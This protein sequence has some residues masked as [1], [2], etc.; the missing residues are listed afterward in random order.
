MKIKSL[1]KKGTQIVI[2]NKVNNNTS[3]SV[4]LEANKQDSFEKSKQKVTVGDPTNQEPLQEYNS[5]TQKEQLKNALVKTYEEQS[6]NE[7]NDRL[8]NEEEKSLQFAA[9][10]QAIEKKLSEIKKYFHLTDS[11]NNML[12]QDSDLEKTKEIIK[13]DIDEGPVKK[14]DR[15][16]K[17]HYVKQNQDSFMKPNNHVSVG[18][19]A[20]PAQLEISHKHKKGLLTIED[21]LPGDEFNQLH[22]YFKENDIITIM[23][24]VDFELETLYFIPGIPE[25][26]VSQ[27]IENIRPY[28]N[29]S[30]GKLKELNTQ[31]IPEKDMIE[32]EI[33]FENNNSKFSDVSISSDIIEQANIEVVAN[34]SHEKQTLDIPIAEFYQE[35]PR[36]QSF[37]QYCHQNGKT[38]MSEITRDD[39]YKIKGMERY[40]IKAIES[41]FTTWTTFLHIRSDKSA[42]DRYFMQKNFGGLSRGNLFIQGCYKEGIFSV[43]DLLQYDLFSLELPSIGQK[44]IKEIHKAFLSSLHNP[45][46]IS[47][48]PPITIGPIPEENQF[49]PLKSLYALGINSENIEKF[50]TK[51]II[52]ASD[53]Y[54]NEISH[55]EYA[56]AKK[57]LDI[58]QVPLP[59]LITSHFT[60]LDERNRILIEARI[61]GKTLQQIGESNNITRERVRQ[62]TNKTIRRSQPLINIFNQVMI[63]KYNGVYSF[64]DIE[65][66]F[67]NESIAKMTIFALTELNLSYY[68]NFSHIFLDK[69]LVPVDIEQILNHIAI[70]IIGKGVDYSKQTDA[71]ESELS[72]HALEF[73]SPND[74]MNYLISSGY[75][76]Y[77]D[78]VTKRKGSYALICLD[79]IKKHFNFDI[80]LDQDENNEDMQNLREIVKIEYPG[81][82]LPEDNHALYS[83]VSSYLVLS[84]RGRYCPIEKVV[85]CSE[86]FE[87]IFEYI[88]TSALTSF[89]YTELFSEYQGQ[90]LA[91]T[92]ID[93]SH[94]LHGVLKYLY[95]NAY[96]YERD[97]L[98]KRGEER[99]DINFR[100]NDM[101]ANLS[102]PITKKEIEKNL[103]G[104]NSWVITMTIDRLP[105]VI[106]WDYNEFMHISNIDIKEDEINCI[107]QIILSEMEE[108]AG[109]AS[110][111]MIFNSI[112]KELPQVIMRNKIKS[113]QNIFYISSW[114]LEG[115][116]RFSRPHIVSLDFPVDDLSIINITKIL[117]GEPEKLNYQDLIGFTENLAWNKGTVNALLSKIFNDYIRISENEYVKPS[118][119]TIS[120]SERCEV[121]NHLSDIFPASG[122]FSIAN[123]YDFSYFP[124]L[125]IL[126]ANELE[127]NGFLLES[128]IEEVYLGYAIVSPKAKD[129]RVQKGL[130]VKYGSSVSS[131][132]DLIVNTLSADNKQRLTEEEFI[133]FLKSKGLSNSSYLPQELY[134]CQNLIYSNGIFQLETLM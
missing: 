111:M 55:W 49:I 29:Y 83:R 130:I 58:L 45:T 85:Y 110:E 52:Y 31:L 34:T 50:H 113:S 23:D 15:E 16:P 90:F 88:E 9:N 51:G 118:I 89:Y 8:S 104:I 17:G 19:P 119:F 121:S 39:F 109:Y 12:K 93:N 71:I 47:H 91:E 101:L 124:E 24:L 73:L 134:D 37:I 53:L 92:N 112:K 122:Y 105:D 46:I 129:R 117:L 62:I 133:A 96:A 61:D 69:S 127:W 115:K 126:Q 20:A 6:M 66:F 87:E 72:E 13:K 14:Q 123:I 26:L 42:R 25:E 79:T 132:S 21:I 56:Y 82:I 54:Q 59:Q 99:Q 76:F 18:T 106:Q 7:T 74:F 77:G 64:D 70:D 60:K 2:A 78:F 86:I 84:G 114:I 63:K 30:Q 103:P 32:Q 95:P 120:E 102:G 48:L 35:I 80:K 33:E 57:M 1:K 10:A 100:I 131:F 81:I 108:H 116:Y 75:H 22:F 107:D 40:G 94:L 128:L 36:S 41:M 11:L 4:Q 44:A 98:K 43:S 65:T 68:M 28:M 38:L 125:E 5:L 67:G 3:L 97:L 27:A